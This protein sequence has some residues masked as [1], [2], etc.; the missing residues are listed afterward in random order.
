MKRK[1][2]LIA[3]A[4]ILAVAIAISV[5]L[6]LFSTTPDDN[7]EGSSAIVIDPVVPNHKLLE[8]ALM[9]SD[10][11]QAG[12]S[13]FSYVPEN[14]P[15]DLRQMDMG[16]GG[17]LTVDAYKIDGGAINAFVQFSSDSKS[18]CSYMA[19]GQNSGLCVREGRNTAAAS[20]DSDFSFVSVYLTAR[21]GGTPDT[22]DAEVKAAERYWARVQF[23]PVDKSP[24][25]GRLVADARVAP[26]V[27]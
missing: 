20:E 8:T 6:G 25:F 4:L 16:G 15:Q 10:A 13:N 3:G 22:D 24:W 17:G 9:I 14:A 21:E 26:R 1:R 7:N 5:R 19:S 27:P 2:A 11:R 23:T 12:V 18:G